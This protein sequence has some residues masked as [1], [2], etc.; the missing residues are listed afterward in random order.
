MNTTRTLLAALFV[1]SIFAVGCGDEVGKC[2]DADRGQDTVISNEVIQ[3]GGQAIINQACAGCHGSEVKGATRQGAP[4]GLDFD[5]L[6]VEEAMA[7]GVA[8]NKGGDPIVELKPEYLRGLRE[9]QRIVFE[10][11]DLIWQQVKDGLMPP[12]GMGAA[13][14]M[15]ANKI[16]D[17][18]DDEPCTRGKPYKDIT[19]KQS[20]D[21]LRNWLACGAPIVESQGPSVKKNLTAGVAGY[22]YMMCGDEP[23]PVGDGGMPVVITLDDVQ[24]RVIDMACTTCHGGAIPPDLSTADK[25]F[26][27]FSTEKCNDKPYLDVAGKDPA[28]S[29]L[30]ELVTKEKPACTAFKMP[31]GGSLSST[32]L[33]LVEDW[34]KAGSPRE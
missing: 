10:E 17:S 6:P 33:R 8:E 27:Y 13:F 31:Q 21:V 20:Q 28:K 29:Y 3:F 25:S 34:I 15:L 18:D 1:S 12:E 2:D 32:Q 4:A 23:A 19:D 30:H 5:L 16:L 9:R 14:R 7:E 24:E 26:E 11:R 22:Q